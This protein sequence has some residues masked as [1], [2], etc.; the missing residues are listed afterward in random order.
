MPRRASGF[1]SSRRAAQ[2]DLCKTTAEMKS[3]IEELERFVDHANAMLAQS[4]I[5]TQ[6]SEVEIVSPLRERLEAAVRVADTHR[7]GLV[8]AKKRWDA[9]L[10]K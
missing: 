6:D 5:L 8:V 4:S 10:G 1:T 3:Q 7:A 9:L 2:P